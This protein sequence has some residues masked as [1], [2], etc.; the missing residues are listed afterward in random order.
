MASGL[1]GQRFAF[2]GYLPVNAGER[3][4]ARSKGKPVLARLL[5][6]L[7]HLLSVV[8]DF[9]LHMNR[10]HWQILGVSDRSSQIPSFGALFRFD[11]QNM[12]Y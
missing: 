11:F 12:Y 3:A 8:Y 1:I 6:L 2:H 4:Q 10:L 5:L 9:V 7:K